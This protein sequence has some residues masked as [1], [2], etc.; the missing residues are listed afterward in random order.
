MLAFRRLAASSQMLLP[1]T[2][3]TP[4][5]QPPAHPPNCQRTPPSK[6]ATHKS[7]KNE[8]KHKAQSQASW[9]IISPKLGRAVDSPIQQQHTYTHTHSLSHTHTH[10][11]YIPTSTF[12]FAYNAW[13]RGGFGQVL[14]LLAEWG[15]VCSCVL[16]YYPGEALKILLR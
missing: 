11:H 7:N 10:T 16:T 15:V 5:V 9:L 4:P 2:V 8:D 13:R 14:G 1:L 12:I 3:A 6:A